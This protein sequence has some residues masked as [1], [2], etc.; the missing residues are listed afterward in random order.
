MAPA[1]APGPSSIGTPNLLPSSLVNPSV[2][3]PASASAS[4][5]Q[6]LRW[7]PIK[8]ESQVKSS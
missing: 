6:A 7:P 8:P 5:S 1:R 2:G 3:A 4:A